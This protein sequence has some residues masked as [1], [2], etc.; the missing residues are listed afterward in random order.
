MKKT[1]SRAKETLGPTQR[2]L[3]AGEN[4]RHILVE[5][6][7]RGEIHDPALK[8]V[9]LT[10]GE[11]RMSPDLKHANI[12]VSAL[13]HKDAKV[14]ADALN[15]ASNYI[16]GLLARAIDSKFTPKLKFI[17]DESYD[18]A[19]HIDELLANP[20]VSRDLEHPKFRLDI[21]NDDE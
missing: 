6:L 9:S 14:F 16:R 4:I 19:L 5:V 12:F 1:N 11:V 10:I 18:I 13:G 2:Q 15:H 3:R 21:H 7:A 8:G 20:K 17:G